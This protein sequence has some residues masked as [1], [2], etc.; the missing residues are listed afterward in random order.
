ML[1]K[2]CS[3]THMLGLSEQKTKF[4]FQVH[5]CESAQ[6]GIKRDGCTRLKR[7]QTS[8]NI[9]FLF[10]S[11]C[12]NLPKPPAERERERERERDPSKHKQVQTHPQSAVVLSPAKRLKHRVHSAPSSRDTSKSSNLPCSHSNSLMKLLFC[13]FCLQLRRRL[14]SAFLQVSTTEF[15]PAALY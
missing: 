8:V 14:R 1:A 9:C 5:D 10:E 3:H 15:R 6:T 2:S 7:C 12:E 13:L 4:L 11:I